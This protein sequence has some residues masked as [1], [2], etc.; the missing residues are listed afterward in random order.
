V[1]IH[2]STLALS[3]LLLVGCFD[4]GGTLTSAPHADQSQPFV[5]SKTVLSDPD[6]DPYTPENMSRA[7]NALLAEVAT[8]SSGT[9]TSES[10]E[11]KANYL[12]VRFLANGK[13]GAAALKQ[14]DTDLV[15]FDHPLDY[16][17]LPKRI[18]YRDPSLPD[19]IIPLFASVPVGYSFGSTPYE[20]IKELFLTEPFDDTAMDES[21]VATV[22]SRA[23]SQFSARQI[24]GGTVKLATVLEN[25]KI[26]L[27]Q[28]QLASLLQTG[29]L[30]ESQLYGSENANS[31]GARSQPIDLGSILAW[32][33]SRWRPSG[34]LKFQDDHLG[35]QPLV[36]VRVTAGYSYYWRE[37]KTDGNG[38]FQS[39]ERWTYS[40]D[41]E[42]NFDCN[43]FLLEDGHSWY[44][45]D[46][47]IE[48]NSS[49]SAWNET[50]TGNQAKWSVIWTGAYQYY[51]GN[52]DGLKRPREN[53]YLNFSLDIQV[54]DGIEN[55][56]KYIW[57]GDEAPAWYFTIGAA[58]WIEIST[59]GKSSFDLYGAIMHELSHS[60]HYE[61][62]GINWW[63]ERTAQFYLLSDRMRESFAAGLESYFC[64]QRYPNSLPRRFQKLYTGI[65]VDLM[66][67]QNLD[68][69]EDVAKGVVQ[70]DMVGG[71]TVQQIQYTWLR[72][73]T[74]DGFKANLKS[75]YP[76]S[77][78]QSYNY[79]SS[80]L[81]NLFAHWGN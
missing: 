1:K 3:A 75:D 56:E 22:S 31:F 5:T 35:P 69:A 81:D 45:E 62:L 6:Q 73:A 48:K 24:G 10:Y 47:E 43:Q 51:Y 32:S 64:S 55:T 44:G 49:K 2:F 19:S 30:S 23:A 8:R 33:W 15:L 20:V 12:Y 21:A 27:D 76:D 16:K 17:P 78:G 18:V 65:Y 25:N 60:V 72:S 28:I 11:L 46:L 59:K 26:S 41:Y 61:H 40:V 68:Y 63:E 74:W 42:A 70:G 57:D 58:D 37:S 4:Q 14:H 80:A 54:Y 79:T 66:D 52:I 7:L 29:N 50:F 39:P 13:R 34:T 38:Y 77:S 9:Q 71:F 36:G 67:A 53:G